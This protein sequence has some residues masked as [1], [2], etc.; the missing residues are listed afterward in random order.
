MKND[1]KTHSQ[2]NPSIAPVPTHAPAAAHDPGKPIQMAAHKRAD[3]SNGTAQAAG[4][5]STDP[6][7]HTGHIRHALKDLVAHLRRDI[8]RVAEPKARVLF[9]TTAEVLQGLVKTYD[10]YDAAKE[11]AFR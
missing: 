11:T 6:K 7:V 9:E 3:S 8:E 4:E 5:D 2:P 1:P 10:D